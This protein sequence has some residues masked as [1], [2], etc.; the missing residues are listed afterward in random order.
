MSR[1]TLFGPG[2]DHAGRAL[3]TDAVQLLQ[4]IG[5]LP[6][7]IEDLG[8]EGLHQLAGEVGTDAFHHARAEIPLDTLQRGGGTTRSCVVLNCRPCVRSVTHQPIPSMYSPG[9]MVGAV[10]TT[11][12]RSRWPRT[13]DTEHAEARL[14][15]VKSHA[16]H[17][18]REVFQGCPGA[19][20]A[21]SVA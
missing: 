18:A 21:S 7:D 12:T 13:L 19:A 6:D 9:V 4:A 8:A 5:G 1:M 17:A 20:M 15:T 11:V 2:C 10:P 14:L 16:F 3:G